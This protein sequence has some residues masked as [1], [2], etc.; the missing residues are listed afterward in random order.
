MRTIL[1]FF[2]GLFIGGIVGLLAAAFCAAAA[3]DKDDKAEY[4]RYLSSI[5]DPRD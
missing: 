5:H 3:R 2:A 1:V 4:Q